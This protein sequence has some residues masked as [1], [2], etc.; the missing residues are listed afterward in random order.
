MIIYFALI[1]TRSLADAGAFPQTNN[2]YTQ[3]LLDWT[4]LRLTMSVLGPAG[5]TE[6]TQLETLR[7]VSLVLRGG[8]VAA[9]AVRAS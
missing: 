3:F 5:R 2:A 7:I 8:I 1:V 4:L 6:L 9:L